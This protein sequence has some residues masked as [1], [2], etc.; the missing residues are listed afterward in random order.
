[1]PIRSSVSTTPLPWKRSLC[2][3][4][5]EKRENVSTIVKTRGVIDAIG[6]DNSR[7]PRVGDNGLGITKAVL[8]QIFEKFVHAEAP[9]RAVADRGESTGLAIFCSLKVFMQS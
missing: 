2:P 6:D 4:A 1:M 3:T 5:G 7:S 9:G 8:P